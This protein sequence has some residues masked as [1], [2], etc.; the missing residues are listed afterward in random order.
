VEL[1]DVARKYFDAWNHRDPAAIAS[2]FAEGGTY[3]NPATGHPLTKEA[4]V[5][6]AQHLLAAFPDLT[7]EIQSLT[8]IDAQQVAVQWCMRG[9][10]TGPFAGFPP[11]GN[12]VALPGADFLVIKRNYVHAVQGY[13]DQKTLA[14]QLG[15]QVNVLPHTLGPFS[16]GW[17][18]HLPPRVRTQ[19]GALSLTII[20][21]RSAEERETIREYSQRVVREDMMQMP[22]FLSFMG[23]WQGLRGFTLSTWENVDKA[24][25]LFRSPVHKEAIDQF[26]RELS[27]GAI[28]SVWVP[29]HVN[30][31]WTRC[32]SCGQM[33]NA[34]APDGRC[35]YGAPVS[36]NQP[37]W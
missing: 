15:L 22:G 18:V 21:A 36:E 2:T 5:S 34:K 23:G 26:F 13:F 24:Q 12:A 4:L 6:Y 35:T 14:E 11:S 1:L 16:Y 3:S 17:S 30:T 31:I 32:T 19:P 29:H 10:N 9:T 27:L 37:H 7:F 28:T 8:A 25:Q 20:Q 33:A